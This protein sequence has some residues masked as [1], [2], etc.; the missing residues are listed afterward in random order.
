M[1]KPTQSGAI[2]AR[3][4]VQEMFG[5]IAPRYDLMNRVMT[6]GQD[7]RWRQL[8]VAAATEEGGDRFLDIATGTGDLALA[9]ANTVAGQVVGLDFS[10]PMIAHADAKRGQRSNVTFVVG[11][12]MHLPFPDGTFAACTISFGLRNLPDYAAGIR[13]MLRVLQPGGRLV[14]LEMTPYRTP[15]LGSLFNTYFTQVVP[16]IGGVISGDR[17]AYRY[18]PDSVAGF[19]DVVSLAVMMRQAGFSQ[20]TWRK[21]GGGT[22]A[23]HTAVK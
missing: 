2:A 22:V 16:R 12:G 21:L 23:M 5:R 6:G 18:L 9:L 8:S 1:S 19:P 4:Q 17:S 15:V 14:V 3:D 13:E 20:V 11:D 10:A 7:I